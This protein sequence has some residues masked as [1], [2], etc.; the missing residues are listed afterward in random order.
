[1]RRVLEKA[2]GELCTQGPPHSHSEV[3][4]E[5]LPRGS[6]ESSIRVWWML[7]GKSGGQ[8]WAEACFLREIESSPCSAGLACRPD[9]VRAKHCFPGPDGLIQKRDP[10]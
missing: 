2:F 7:A 5:W 10:S 8:G 6:W 9:V 3:W 1:M 4:G